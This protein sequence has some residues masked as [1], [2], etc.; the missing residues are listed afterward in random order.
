MKYRSPIAVLV[1][2]N[3]V[4]LL[5]DV[6]DLVTDKRYSEISTIKIQQDWTDN[7]VAQIII[8]DEEEDS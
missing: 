2:L 8:H 7:W 1:N 3:L 5:S 6:K 4:E